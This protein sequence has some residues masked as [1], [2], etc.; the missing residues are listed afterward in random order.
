[1]DTISLQPDCSRC[2]ALCCLSLAFDRSALFAFDKAAG[3]AC[4]HL[5][6]R[7][8][9]NIH[10]QRERRGFGGCAAYDC[11]GAGQRV[12]QELFGGRSW[13]DDPALVAPMME[14]FWAMRQVH[15]SWLLLRLSDS[16]HRSGHLHL[17]PQ[18]AEARCELE[19]ILQPTEGQAL[20][21][22]RAFERER[23]ASKVAAFLKSVRAQSSPC[24]EPPPST[25][26]T[27]RHL[28]VIASAPSEAS[29]PPHNK[30]S[31]TL[32][33]DTCS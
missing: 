21:E 32:A 4:S 18:Q 29:G 30:P 1:L 13:R 9:C 15:E 3:S 5:G 33:G 6:A 17:T 28:P 2:V 23:L 20:S 19:R 22:I 7:H 16:L 27:P 12:T 25:G 11:L 26:Y 24:S 10:A 8:R 31:H 14:A